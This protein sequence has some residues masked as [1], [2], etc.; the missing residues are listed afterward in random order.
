MARNAGKVFEDDFKASVPKDVYF[1]RLHDAALGFDVK[2]ST[3]RFSLKSPYDAILC[4][5]GQM[6]AIEL[7]SHKGKMLGFDSK[8]API[9]RRQIENLVKAGGAGAVSGIVIN[10]RDYEETYYID[11]K[12]FLE[13]MNTC[14]KKSVNLEDAR[15]MGIRIPEHKKVT[16][17]TYDIEPI[18][19]LTGKRKT[20]QFVATGYAK[21]VSSIID[22]TVSTTE[23]EV[24]FRCVSS[25]E[26]Q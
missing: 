2:H 15:K 1:V 26:K 18:L 11:A 4:K 17:S 14:G 23:K 25:V 20:K 16:H 9:K 5:N 7:K 8:S 10:F 24:N 6:Y 3:Q 13:F 21:P 19:S 12:I 22:N